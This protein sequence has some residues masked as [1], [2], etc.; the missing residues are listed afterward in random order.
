MSYLHGVN[1]LYKEI[2]EDHNVIMS[3]LAIANIRQV[4]KLMTKPLVISLKHAL[5]VNH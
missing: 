2:S 1:Y 4:R 5:L 3:F